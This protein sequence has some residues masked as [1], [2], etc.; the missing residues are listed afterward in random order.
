MIDLK[1]YDYNFY[2][3]SVP[4]NPLQN[5]WTCLKYKRKVDDQISFQ[6]KNKFSAVPTDSN[7]RF[8]SIV[9]KLGLFI[10]VNNSS[11]KYG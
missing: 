4:E 3:L 10:H 7:L 11:S 5:V 1:T 9:I 2:K 6:N 8:S